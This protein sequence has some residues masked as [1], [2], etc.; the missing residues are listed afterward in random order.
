M[1]IKK[2][3][4]PITINTILNSAPMLIQGAGRLIELI[5]ERREETQNP[6]EPGTVPP[7]DQGEVLG[8]IVKRL[9]AMDE[10]GVQ[11]ARIVEQLARQNE[12]LAG[13]LRRALRRA[14][15]ALVLALAALLAGAPALTA[16]LT[17]AA[18]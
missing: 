12:A 13:A 10:A 6:P 3:M 17:M 14:N 16:L 7:A 18:T 8:E 2:V 1:A 11:Q 15:I 9:E 4:N 5:R